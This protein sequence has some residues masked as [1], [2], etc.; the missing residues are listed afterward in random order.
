MWSA[1]TYKRPRPAHVYQALQTV[2]PTPQHPS[3]PSNH[4]LQNKLIHLC[5]AGALPKP[6]ADALD[7]PMAALAFRIADNRE[8]A[9]VHYPSDTLAGMDILAPRVFEV[10]RGQSGGE[11]R[12]STPCA[13]P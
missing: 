10:L 3:F 4:T 13:R 1:I 6:V 2:V 12:S 5:L 8:V 7:A 9:G 11:K